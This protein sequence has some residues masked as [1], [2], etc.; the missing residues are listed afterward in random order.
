MTINSNRR[1]GERVFVKKR[2][3]RKSSGYLL[4]VRFDENT[5]KDATFYYR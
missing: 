2:T 4:A 1:R 3:E 5:C